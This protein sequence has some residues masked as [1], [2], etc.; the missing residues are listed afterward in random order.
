MP[1]TEGLELDDLLP[2]L[3][4]K[5]RDLMKLGAGLLF[6]ACY[7]AALGY[8]VYRYLASPA[9]R[10]A[11]AGAVTEVTLPGAMEL[12]QGTALMFK[13]GTRPSMLIHQADGSWTALD[14]VCTHLGCTVLHEPDKNRIYCACHGGEYDPLTGRNTGGPPPKPL[15][16]YKVEVRDG[17]IVVLRG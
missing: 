13:F 15:K 5:R 4:I 3:E 6:G 17:Q 11:E 2:D 7:G 1:E 14:A 16:S 9:I 12:P 8:P 10:E